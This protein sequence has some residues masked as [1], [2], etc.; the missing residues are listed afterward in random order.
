MS[1]TATQADTR[2]R[3][4]RNQI[5]EVLRKPPSTKPHHQDRMSWDQAELVADE[6]MKV[7]NPPHTSSLAYEID[8]ALKALIERK[9]T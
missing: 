2:Y 5:V 1:E 3:A 6:I 4:T 7:L 8:T 9:D